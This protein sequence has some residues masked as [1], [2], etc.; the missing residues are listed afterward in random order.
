FLLLAA[1]LPLLTWFLVT[2]HTPDSITS[3]VL[4]YQLLVVLVALTGG[5]WPALTAAV[6]SG[7]TLDYFFIDPKH[8][9]TISE[10]QHVLAIVLYVLIAALVSVVVDRAARQAR[11]ARR[12]A[13]EAELL[14]TISGSVLRGQ[15]AVPA[16]LERTREAFGVSRVRL[17]DGST[18][19]AESSAD[20]RDH[21]EVVDAGQ[22]AD[23]EPFRV[24][25]GERAELELTG[26]VIAASERRLLG[27]I[28]AQVAA[29]L[30]HRDL[31]ET[32]SELGTLE[33]TDRVRSALL[34]AVSHDLRR[35][36]AAATAAVGGL[37]TAGARLDP[38]DRAELLDT[39]EESLGTLAA[40]VTDLLDV[41]RLEVGA[42]AVALRPIDPADAIL[43]AL[44]ELGLGPGQVALDL[45]E[46]A[47]P[48]LADP[49][50]LQRVLVN[51][52]ANAG[53][54]TPEGERIRL[55]TSAF[56]TRA[57]IRV[58]DHGP[59]I[60]PE[61]R[62]SVFEPFQRRGDTEND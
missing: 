34:S 9:V 49:A 5:V 52:L 28:A 56:G 15:Q 3:D 61:R 21:A 45:R 51:L 60:A 12:A 17:L 30:E 58:I 42:V 2:R 8:T 44:D 47:G 22:A 55:T 10:P 18:V 23:A 32:A 53:R 14:A 38:A 62:E 26:G 27:V 24:P 6:L 16:L 39:A 41:S 59:G 20:T 31:S 40:L 36:L 37:R 54:F 25:V 33:E 4:S 57:E 48:V 29:A 7:I 19:L 13:A 35:P 1:G 43:P 50:L 11:A 46:D